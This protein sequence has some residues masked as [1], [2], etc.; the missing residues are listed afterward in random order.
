MDAEHYIC[1][2]IRTYASWGRRYIAFTDYDMQ[3]LE[4][5]HW[6]FV[7]FITSYNVTSEILLVYQKS[8]IL[9]RLKKLMCEK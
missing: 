1:D 3:I 7:I 9:I 2:T 5:K 4:V 8:K 6:S